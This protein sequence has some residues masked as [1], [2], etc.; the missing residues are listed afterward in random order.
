LARRYFALVANGVFI[1]TGREQPMRFDVLVASIPV[2]WD[3]RME[4]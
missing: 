4:A 2:G 3:G 1:F